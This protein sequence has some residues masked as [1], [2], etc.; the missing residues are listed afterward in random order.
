M[1]FRVL[2]MIAAAAA[3]AAA[4][5]PSRNASA[6]ETKHVTITPSVSR[7][8]GRVSLIVDVAPKPKMHVYTPEQK[9]Y[10]SISL[11]LNPVDGVKAGQ[12]VFPKGEKL[13][14]PEL[15]ETQIVYSKPFRITQPVTLAK[16]AVSEMTITGTVRY[17]AC[18][19]SICYLPQDVPVTWQIGR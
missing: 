16:G 8:S 2:L 1:L 14:F 7:T 13:F 18:D 9:G 6:V 17:Q 4:Q 15:K 12:A 11:T 19:D 3:I 10:I 5:V